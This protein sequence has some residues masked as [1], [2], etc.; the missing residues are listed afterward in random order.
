M[1]K[2]LVVQSKEQQEILLCLDEAR[3]QIEKLDIKMKTM[4]NNGKKA[5]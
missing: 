5:W 2:V 3:K 4:A 1:G